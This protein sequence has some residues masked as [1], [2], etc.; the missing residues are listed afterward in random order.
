MLALEPIVVCI[1]AYI[2]LVYG[3]LYLFFTAYPISFCELRNRRSAGIAALP[4]VGI[5]IGVDLGCIF[6]TYCTKKYFA[7][8]L[9]AAGRVIPEDRLPPMMFAAVLLPVGL[10]WFGWTSDPHISWA[11]QAVA[12]VPIGM[13]IL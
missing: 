7:R 13:G 1:T 9:K 12:G 2:S 10:F 5:I 8:R 4:F 6:V 3:I 11:A